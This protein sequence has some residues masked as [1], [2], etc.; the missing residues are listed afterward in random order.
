VKYPTLSTGIKF[1]VMMGLIIALVMSI[2]WREVFVLLTDVNIRIVIVYALVLLAG[3]LVSVWRWSIVATPYRFP[4]SLKTLYGYY[5]TASF[6]N[7]FLPSFIGGD[8]YRAY[9][10]GG[11]KRRLIAA[12]TVVAD[13]ATG[14]Y[15][16]LLLAALTGILWT[17]QTHR[18]VIL[19]TVTVLGAATAAIVVRFRHELLAAI[20]RI[21]PRKRYKIFLSHADTMHTSVIYRAVGVGM[22]FGMFGVGMANYLLFVALQESPP[23]LP[24]LFFSLIGAVVSSLPISIGNIGVKEWVYIVFMGS[25]GVHAEHA[26]AAVVL[27]RVVQAL[28]SALGVIPYWTQERAV[29]SQLTQSSTPHHGQ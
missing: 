7:N 22:I 29:V 17:I 1:I 10:L 19:T 16:I 15:G 5:L 14:L 26:V 8:V 2:S 12:L 18:D 28:V 3:N 6:I 9:R 23:I 4:V 20:V 11:A 27:G 13:R 24:F 25:L 21:I